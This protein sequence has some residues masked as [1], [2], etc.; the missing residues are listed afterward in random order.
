MATSLSISQVIMR[1]GLPLVMVLAGLGGMMWFGSEAETAPAEALSHPVILPFDKTQDP[2][3]GIEVPQGMTYIPGG[4][5]IIGSEKGLPME[6][7]TFETTVAPFLMDTHPVTVAQ[8]RAFVEAN[9]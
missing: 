5:T 9:G 3:E 7:P 8:I 1:L 6:K 2:P 4:Q